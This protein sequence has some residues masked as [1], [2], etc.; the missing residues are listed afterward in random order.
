MI[1]PDPQCPLC[2]GTGF[3]TRDGQDA[4]CI[5]VRQR[6][7]QQTPDT[8]GIP[9]KFQRRSFENYEASSTDQRR[10]L[11]QVQ[12][13]VK[14]LAAH[15][16]SAQAGQ[17][18][19]PFPETLSGPSLLGAEKN[20]LMLYGGVGSGKTHL[21]VAA[22]RTLLSAGYTGR[23]WNVSELFRAIRA[24]FGEGEGDSDLLDDIAACDVL[25]LDDLGTHRNTDFV[26][27]RLYLIIN[28]R[29][30]SLR[31]LIT[32]TNLTLQQLF[33]EFDQRIAS[34]LFEMCQQVAFTSGDYRLTAVEKRTKRG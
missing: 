14:R 32:T 34:R 13:Y 23:Y 16:P 27:D 5:C 11:G 20:G 31:P 4:A 6:A 33:E 3:V 7:E 28:Q 12:E 9:P 2:R 15:A 24:Q 25:V 8:A 30:D 17:V 21:A 10:V 1:E 18:V 22:M 29:Y 19:T 26:L